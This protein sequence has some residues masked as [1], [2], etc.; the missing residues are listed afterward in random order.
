MGQ[1]VMYRDN[2]YDLKGR[3]KQSRETT[4]RKTALSWPKTIVPRTWETWWDEKI[5]EIFPESITEEMER[6]QSTPESQVT[7][8]GKYA[9]VG[10]VIFEKKEVE[11]DS[12]MKRQRESKWGN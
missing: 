9:V 5:S 12:D 2:L 6:N 10:G 8:D 7:S 4:G 1:K 3:R 11:E